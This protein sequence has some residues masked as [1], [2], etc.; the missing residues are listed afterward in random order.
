MSARKRKRQRVSAKKGAEHYASGG[1]ASFL[2][3]PEGFEMFSPEAKRY[4]LDFMP[5]IVGKGNPVA[6][7]GSE[8]FEREF[9]VHKNVGPDRD[10]FVCPARTFKKPCPICEYLR[11]KVDDPDMS[12]DEIKEHRRAYGAKTRVLYLVRDLDADGPDGQVKVYNESAYT[13]AKPLYGKINAGDE[14]DGYDFFYDP[15]EGKTVRVMFQQAEGGKWLEVADMEFRGRKHGYDADVA[16]E[17]PC[18]DDMLICLPYDKL[19]R[20]FLAIDD[21]DEECE[22]ESKATFEEDEPEVEDEVEDEPEPE[23]VKPKKKSSKPKGKKDPPKKPSV[24]V[25][26]GDKVLYDGNTC[27]VLKVSGD[28]TSLVLEDVDSEEIY[29]PVDTNEVEVVEDDEDVDA[30]EVEEDVP[31]AEEPAPEE[32]EDEEPA[33]DEDED[34]DDDDDKG[35]GGDDDW[36]WDDDEEED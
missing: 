28:G 4:R 15:E 27:L 11:K 3:V 23:P 21:G 25:S 26:R 16:D 10:W 31:E 24:K 13:F 33:D 5:Y 32:D 1:M 6:K 18:L 9:F 20:I 14:E 30:D 22:E 36:N 8:Y 17:M 2:L 35:S 19:K 34:E 12:E 7:E 29:R